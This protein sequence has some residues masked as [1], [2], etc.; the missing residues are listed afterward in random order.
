MGDFLKNLKDAVENEEFNSEA[1]QRINKISEL[2]DDKTLEGSQE[3]IDKRLEAAGVKN[4]T[5]EEAVAISSQYEEK[6]AKIKERDG[7]NAQ[8][9]TLIEID[10][11]VKLSIGDMF[12]FIEGLEEKFA[13][14]F[15]DVDLEKAQE[16]KEFPV[17]NKEYYE[18]KG[19]IALIRNRFDS[20]L[21]K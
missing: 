4:V 3:D 7:V 11:M 9:A 21:V 18:L 19:Q 15:K 16:D 6:M 20:L 1:A 8:L 13:E 10:D 2:A 14:K 17:E 5:A 12:E